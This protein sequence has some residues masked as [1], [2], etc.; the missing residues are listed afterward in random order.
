[1]SVKVLAALPA[2]TMPPVPPSP[3]VGTGKPAMFS[4]PPLMVTGPVPSSGLGN[5]RLAV[6]KTTP[7][8]S[9]KPPEVEFGEISDNVPL[10][11]LTMVP[12]PALNW[13][14]SS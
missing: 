4:V 7:S 9:M 8:P 2:V 12:A 14:L 5:A 13:G 1:M 10:P 6:A 3:A 11:S